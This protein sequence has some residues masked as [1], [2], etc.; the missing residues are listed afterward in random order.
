M[1]EL[2]NNYF[3][4][5]SEVIYRVAI[6]VRLSREDEKDEKDEN[7]RGQ[8]GSIENQI[9]F[10]KPIVEN[11][12]WILIDIYKDDGYTG[13]NFERPGFKRMIEDIEIGKINLVITKDL[14]RLGRDYIET[15]RYIEKYFPSRN[16]RYIAV[17]DNIDTFDKK[18]TNND[19]TPFKSV[20]NDM[21]A[22]DISNKVR[23]AMYT[24]AREG[25]CI[26]AFLPYGYK[27][28][29]KDK[30][31]I[32]IDENVADNIKLIF[33][34]YKLG[35]NKTEIARHLNGLNI[36]TPLRYKQENTNYFNPNKNYSNIWNSTVIN[37]IL[38]DKIY[39]GDLVQLK[40]TKINYKIKK[41][42][43]NS[44]S[45]QIIIPNHHPAIIDRSTFDTVQEMLDK[46]SNEWNYGNKKKHLLTGLVYCTCGAKIGYNKNHGKFFRCVCSSYKK[47]GNKFCSNVHMREDNLLETVATSL[48][49]NINK[50][51]N[52]DN[53]QY[54]NVNTK[55][56]EDNKKYIKL[57][58]KKKD[59]IDR[60]ISNL[61]EDKIS[62][63]ISLDTFT[64]LMRKY[65]KQRQECEE[66]IK[67]L[68]QEQKNQ[69]LQNNI[70]NEDI[71]NT[72]KKILKFD[73]IN[74]TNTSLAFKLIDRIIIDDRDIHIKYK[75]NIPA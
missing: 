54:N 46:Q 64:N 51:L 45:E 35:K 43:K 62:E 66:K 68:K 36:K 44:E 28:D 15:G 17:N 31:I 72:V 41:T 14:S 26:K 67:K 19:M 65:E 20:M 5:K 21:Y 10:L 40:Y 39:V 22:K 7:Y 55:V 13:T 12:G 70:T 38:R 33:N 37:K 58:N 4:T 47:S 49:D 30:N 60:I 32:L 53:L 57:I 25:E 42:I 29:P 23:T 48:K 69:V 24:K 61:Y 71:E 50:Y 8:S 27:K 16:V 52:V 75:F 63:L 3:N 2:Y 1:N 18:N 6:Y 73:E 74:S 59:E 9:N 11:K 56:N 34:L